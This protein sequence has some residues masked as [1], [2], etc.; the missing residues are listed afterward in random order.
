M[1]CRTRAG[2]GDA[3]GRP[4]QLRLQDVR[5]TAAAQA[6]SRTDKC[7]VVIYRCDMWSSR[8]GL[9][10]RSADWNIRSPRTHGSRRNARKHLV[11]TCS[12]SNRSATAQHVCPGLFTSPLHTSSRPPTRLFTS[13]LHASSR[14]PTRL[15][16]PPY[17]PL[18]VPLH[19]SSRL[20][21]W[22]LLCASGPPH[23]AADGARCPGGGSG[24]QEDVS[25]K[26]ASARDVSHKTADLC[27]FKTA[28]ARLFW[29]A[30]W[31]EDQVW[32]GGPGP[33][34]HP[35]LFVSASRDPGSDLHEAVD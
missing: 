23:Q 19:A 31:L 17:T 8:S 16:T 11:L 10:G 18:H 4:R 25:H 6:G 34:L 15:F 22:V 3:C 30:R 26:T 33:S 14:P 5:V 32:P 21:V 29:R 35:A 9:A 13:P 7:C 2:H 12:C 1:S 28:D 20:S 27:V 24:S